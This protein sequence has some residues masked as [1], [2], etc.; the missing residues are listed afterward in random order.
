MKN[1]IS[2]LCMLLFGVTSLYSASVE[3]DSNFDIFETLGDGDKEFDF[4]GYSGREYSRNGL[5]YKVVQPKIANEKHSW[6]IRARFWGHEPQLD[7]QLLEQGFHVVYCDVANLYGSKEAVKRWNQ[8]YKIMQK[9]GLNDKVVLEG[10]SR[11][12]LIVYNW[13]VKNPKRVS[14]IYADAPVLDL[15]SWPMGHPKYTKERDSML[16]AY[17]KSEAE[18]LKYRGNPIDNASK[19]AKYKIPIIHV[20]GGAD[21]VVPYADNTA[22]FAEILMANGAE[23]EVVVKEGVGHHPHSLKDPT[24]IVEFILRAEEV[25]IR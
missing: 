1:L 8:F 9:A 25:E 16:R 22:P 21:D 3:G 14:A 24:Q 12:G 11:G 7:R 18:M 15:K 10:M 6:I 4:H 2:L 5:N 23:I 17:G 13:M 19:I 20:V